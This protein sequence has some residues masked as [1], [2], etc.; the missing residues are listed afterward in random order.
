M[1][2]SIYG[3]PASVNLVDFD[4]PR[5][6]PPA[7]WSCCVR[8]RAIPVPEVAT[9]SNQLEFAV[10]LPLYDAAGCVIDIRR[11]SVL[12]G[13]GR[14]GLKAAAEMLKRLALR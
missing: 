3:L 11:Y 9:E 12:S 4:P 1:F 8:T 14:D 10:G 7:M 2:S 5:V 6:S 13:I